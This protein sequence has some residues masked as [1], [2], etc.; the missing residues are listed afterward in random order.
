MTPGQMVLEAVHG[1]RGGY[2]RLALVVG[3]PRSGKT[4]ALRWAAEHLPFP[5]INVNL[6]LAQRLLPYSRQERPRAAG[7]ALSELLAGQTTEVVG[8]DNLELLFS[9]ELKLDP[10]RLLQSESRHRSLVATWNGCR[11]GSELR[12]ARPGHPEF[13][14]FR[15]PATPIISTALAATV[16]PM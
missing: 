15:A 1:L 10:L 13:A 2:E 16:E 14:N 11:A 8:L 6:E 12:Y 7:V 5:V 4:T 3:P 9:T